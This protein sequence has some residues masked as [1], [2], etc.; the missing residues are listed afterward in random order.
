MAKVSYSCTRCGEE[1]QAFPSD[2][3][4]GYA[5]YCTQKC[6]SLHT[7]E[8]KLAARVA[9]TQCA[10][11]LTPLWR[12]PSRVA[13]SKSGLFFCCKE[14]Q[15]T[16]RCLNSG[17]TG[18]RP[19]TYG[20][21]T[22]SKSY[23]AKAFSHYDRCCDVCGYDRHTDVLIVHHRDNDHENNDLSNLQILCPTCHAE[24]HYLSRT[25]PWVRSDKQEELF[26]STARLISAEID[27]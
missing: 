5:L 16:A 10:L 4:R 26:L 1:F 20:S 3:A 12:N 27:S 22:S 13:A 14:H 24:I 17:I 19:S 15:D 7:W 25:G 11:C 2:R 18:H 21:G 9:N 23:R 8:K 6:S